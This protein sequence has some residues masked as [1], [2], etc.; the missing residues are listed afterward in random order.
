MKGVMRVA[1]VVV[2]A[3]AAS[4]CAANR[5]VPSVAGAAAAPRFPAY[6]APAVPPGLDVPDDV[7]LRHES[8]WTR[9]QSGDLRGAL[10]EFSTVLKQTPS[11]YPAQVGLGFVHLAGDD[12]DEAEPLFA[13]ASAVDETYLPAWVGRSEALVGLGRD[14]DAI[15]AMQRVLALDPARE[16]VRT[17]VELLRF[18]LTQTS[19]GAGQ[20]ARAAGR[21]AEAIGH[22]ARALE[23]SP[24][25]T[26]IL[27]ELART[28]I[29]AGQLD[30]AERHA[31]QS[32]K[33]EPREAGWQALLG[34]V[35]EARG[36]FSAAA[37]AYDRAE[38]LESS[39]V[40]RARSRNLRERAV[41]A[42][43]PESFRSVTSAGSITRADVAAYI[44][45]HLRDLLAAAPARVTTVATDVRTHWAAAWILP[46]TR[47]GI[48][49]VFPNHT[50]QP[51]AVVRR[52]DL[53]STMAVLV[54]IAAGH[55]PADLSKWQ[56][57]R[58]RFLDLP[59]S[60]L[61]Y[62]SSAVATA[63]GVMSTDTAGRFNPTQPATGAD[64]DQAVRRLAAMATP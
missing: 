18:R 4:A 40:W 6:P 48:M 25:S 12:Y 43:L 34:D 50:F 13:A 52:A 20:Q 10:R 63:A 49:S 33:I 17:R 55:R 31:R 51:A 15:G 59:A 14:A 16:N 56:A 45:I 29:A 42:G 35:L 36:Q 28:E 2:M 61:F 23:Q 54:E 41:I 44:G 60:N 57:A 47:A 38:L 37:E 27:N 5:A 3:V 32:L 30:A 1:V 58:P 46:V 9:L 53:A 39:E 24:D 64:L 26:M 21:H 19:I 11:F 62:A 8:A 22:F 7:R